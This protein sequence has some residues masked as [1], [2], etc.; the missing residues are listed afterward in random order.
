M[1]EVVIWVLFAALLFPV[2]FA[3]WAIG[4]Y[5]SLGGGKGGGAARTVTQTSTTTVTVTTTAAAP[6]TA[7]TTTA[8]APTTSGSTTTASAAGNPDQGKAV[9]AAAGCGSC[10]AYAPAGASGAVGPD[11]DTAPQTDAKTANMALAAF[12]RQSIVE[13]NA[14]VAPGYPKSVMPQTYARQLSKTQLADLVA[15]LAQGAK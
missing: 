11:L 4:H 12:L 8:A 3:G 5:T 1:G 9:F 7:G 6:T 15:F 10:H 2:G 13:P 14:Y